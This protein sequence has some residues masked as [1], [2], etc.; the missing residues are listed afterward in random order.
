[1]VDDAT[2]VLSEIHDVGWDL[3]TSAPFKNIQYEAMGAL[4]VFRRR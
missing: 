4:Y 2:A 3:V 1:M